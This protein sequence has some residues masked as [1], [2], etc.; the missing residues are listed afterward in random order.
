[1]YVYISNSLCHC[2]VMVLHIDA[3]DITVDVCCMA[4]FTCIL[5]L[6]SRQHHKYI[7][8]VL[9]IKRAAI[10]LLTRDRSILGYGSSSVFLYTCNLAHM[11]Q[12]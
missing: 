5:R 10:D 3:Y 7:V 9:I 4:I 12:L 2:A 11:L 8:Q 6:L 1:M